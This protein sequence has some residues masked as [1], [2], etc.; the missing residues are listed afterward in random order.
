MANTAGSGASGPDIEE[1]NGWGGMKQVV[2]ER[3]KSYLETSG[4]NFRFCSS[5]IG[6]WQEFVL[7]HNPRF[8]AVN[9][10]SG[11]LY[12]TGT[13]KGKL[14]L[15]FRK[16]SGGLEI[17]EVRFENEATASI[18]ASHL[19]VLR[20]AATL[21]APAGGAGV[22]QPLLILGA[23]GPMGE[24]INGIYKPA[25]DSLRGGP[26]YQKGNISIAQSMTSRQWKVCRNLEK[27]AFCEEKDVDNPTHAKNW[28]IGGERQASMVVTHDLSLA[29]ASVVEESAPKAQEQT[30]TD[31]KPIRI[32]GAMGEHAEKINGVY[33]PGSAPFNDHPQFEKDGMILRWSMNQEHWKVCDEGAFL[34]EGM[35]AFCTEK[36]LD[37]PTLAKSWMVGTEE[38]ASIVVTYDLNL[39]PAGIEIQES[40]PEKLDNSSEDGMLLTDGDRT[41]TKSGGADLSSVYGKMQVCSGCHVWKVKINQ[42]QPENMHIGIAQPGKI[43][44]GSASWEMSDYVGNAL[45]FIK[46][47]GNTGMND[48]FPPACNLP[49]GH[50]ASVSSALYVIL[51][52]LF[53]HPYV[54][55]PQGGILTRRTSARLIYGRTTRSRFAWISV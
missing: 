54:T 12:S 9:L 23:P 19:L 53:I 46:S 34:N 50:F 42:S 28:V 15:T 25:I 13:Q 11:D 26:K 35:Y 2:L 24:M 16:V 29:S 5:H 38:Q 33:V 36:G 51:S 55:P 21:I 17:L 3:M 47:P 31:G 14:G 49:S 48:S 6:G 37:D 30:V 22:P 52:D 39:A 41:V 10:Q 40:G 1:T 44:P 4:C 27:Y 18:P 45:W 7:W 20:D 43:T 8:D 32:A